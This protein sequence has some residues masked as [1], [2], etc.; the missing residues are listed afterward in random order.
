[1]PGYLPEISKT[2]EKPSGSN[3]PPKRPLPL[4]KETASL[5]EAKPLLVVNPAFHRYW[6]L[7]VGVRFKVNP[8]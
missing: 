1:M 8:D 6:Q 3:Y 5:V 4:G 2:F 7:V